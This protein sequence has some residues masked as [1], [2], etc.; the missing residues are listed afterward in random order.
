MHPCFLKNYQKESAHPQKKENKT[1]MWIPFISLSPTKNQ[2]EQNRLHRT[3]KF[4][5]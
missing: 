2:E 5:N 3:E 1:M 4:L